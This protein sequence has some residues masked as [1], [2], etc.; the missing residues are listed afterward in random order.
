M[1]A[2]WLSMQWGPGVD[3]FRS[4]VKANLRLTLCLDPATEAYRHCAAHYP[5]LL[6]LG[7]AIHIPP[8]PAP[9]GGDRPIGTP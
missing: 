2:I 1:I 4:R 9:P 8:W 7:T 6:R 3:F 5:E